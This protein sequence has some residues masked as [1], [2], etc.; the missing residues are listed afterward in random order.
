MILYDNA[1][2]PFARKVRLVLSLKGLNVEY[3]D[4]LNHDGAERLRDVNGRGEVPALIDEGLV[5]VNSS[6]IVAYLDHQ[7]PGFPVLPACPK[8]RVNARKWERIADSVIDPIMVDISYWAWANRSDEM[9]A[10]MLDAAKN[11]LALIYN[12][13]ERELS[14][15]DYICGELSIAD[16]A[17]FPHMAGAT[18][19]GVPFSKNNHKNIIS[20]LAR[21]RANEMFSDDLRRVS[22][23][24]KNIETSN[25]ER[26]K[27]F[28]RGERIEWVLAKG[29][30]DWFFNE[31]K[32]DRVIWPPQLPI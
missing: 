12:Q 26:T 14:N 30:D 20:W 8:I 2:S 27:L 18:A 3:V 10:G 17:L 7:Y 4:G 19:L 22:D 11:D 29:F 25:V 28:W 6:D 15:S 16:I 1:F 13:L 5:V 32:S 9:P 21:L 24:V 31:I 23:F